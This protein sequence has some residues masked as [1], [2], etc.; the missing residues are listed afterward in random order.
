VVFVGRGSSAVG[1]RSFE[2]AVTFVGKGEGEASGASAGGACA[3]GACA[4]GAC[5]D[6]AACWG[7]DATG[8]WGVLGVVASNV[9]GVGKGNL[10]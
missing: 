4:D 3:D 6:G 5:E 1:G 9:K 2:T 8:G 10:R 7:I